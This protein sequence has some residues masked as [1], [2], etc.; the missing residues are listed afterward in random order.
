M[1]PCFGLLKCLLLAFVKLPL[2]EILE[3]QM[4]FVTGFETTIDYF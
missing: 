1:W 2:K 3:R 4:A